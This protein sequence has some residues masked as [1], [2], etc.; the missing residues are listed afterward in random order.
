MADE[1]WI[2]APAQEGEVMEGQVAG[3]ELLA[4]GVEF[5]VESIDGVHFGEMGVEDAP[6]DGAVHAALLL[7]VGEPLDHV[8]VGQVLLGR[9]GEQVA[10]GA[11]HPR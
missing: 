3:L 5:E 11:G 8:E 2:D 6:L 9:L 7:L 1:E 4:A 10:D